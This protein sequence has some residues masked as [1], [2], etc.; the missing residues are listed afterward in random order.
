EGAVV[1]DAPADLVVQGE[2][3]GDQA[4]VPLHER[5]G[6]QGGVGG[7]F[8]DGGQLGQTRPDPL[9]LG[10]S[11]L[12]ALTV[13]GD[14]LGGVDLVPYRGDRL[15]HDGALIPHER[16]DLAATALEDVPG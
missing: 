6:A 3:V 12:G 9:D 2:Q 16:R 4:G 15:V 10:P 8:T 7:G 11:A 14:Q 5:L 1:G 13:S